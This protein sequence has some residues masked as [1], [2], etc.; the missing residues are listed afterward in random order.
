MT[1]QVQW[2]IRSKDGRVDGPFTTTEV[3][4]KIRAGFYLGEEYISKYP[5]GRWHPISYDQNF[6]NVLLEVLETE[7]EEKPQHVVEHLEESNSF[8]NIS[9]DG[10]RK[11][12]VK[13]RCGME[14]VFYGGKRMQPLCWTGMLG[15]GEEAVRDGR[16]R[17]NG[18]KQ[19]IWL[20]M[21]G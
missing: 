16:T 21:G 13:R 18:S 15:S 5:S 12:K 4:R 10:S 6:F 11:E 7:M 3:V 2:L 14:S 20:A 9:K 19:L 8:V 17:L 1:T